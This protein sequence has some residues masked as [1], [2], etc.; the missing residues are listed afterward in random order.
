VEVAKRELRLQPDTPVIL[1]GISRGAGLSVVAAGQQVMRRALAGVLAVALTREEEHVRFWRF[2]R[3]P[4]TTAASLMVQTYEYLPNL[5]PVPIEV[6]QSTNDNYL[7][8]ADA[9]ELFGA[10]NARR[11]LIAI[12]SRNHSFSDA[13]EELY[14]AMEQSL[15]WLTRQQ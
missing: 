1:V 6:I 12:E 9:R 15:V 7:P 5:G 2:R 10:D 13:R 11:R 3:A 4:G 8:A 14:H